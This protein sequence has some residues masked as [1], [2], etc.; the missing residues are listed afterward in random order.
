[1]DFMGK[2]KGETGLQGL[3]I[4]INTINDIFKI[5]KTYLW[6]LWVKKRVKR[7]F[8]YFFK[9]LKQKGK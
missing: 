8:C 7:C 1:M 5:K 4:T 9:L 3:K 2:K 6:T